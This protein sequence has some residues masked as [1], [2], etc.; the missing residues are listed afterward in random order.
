MRILKTKIAHA[1]R[2][3]ELQAQK[4][5][6]HGLQELIDANLLQKQDEDLS[7]S[8]GLDENLQ[9]KNQKS[10]KPLSS[11]NIMKN[12]SRAFVNFALSRAADHYVSL[13]AEEHNIT[14]A[15]F[16]RFIRKDKHK[17]NCIQSLRNKLL[18]FPDDTDTMARCKKAFQSVCVAFL[19]YFSVNWI[20]HSKVNDKLTHLKYRFKILRRVQ[21][22][23]HFT[24]LREFKKKSKCID[25]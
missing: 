12:Y 9:T 24:Y 25:K 18:V 17:I 16:N 21:D 20:Y 22:P 1:R 14:I 2:C 13:S 7:H 23:Q 4:L 15:Y 19:K 8:Q 11:N 10:R 5:K 3:R 6:T